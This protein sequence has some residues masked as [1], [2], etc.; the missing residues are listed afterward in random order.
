MVSLRLVARPM[1]EVRS[2][3]VII[4]DDAQSRAI[5][6]GAAGGRRQEQVEGLVTLEQR[7]L[8]R[9]DGDSLGC[10]A[11]GEVQRAVGRDKVQPPKQSRATC[12]S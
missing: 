6:H 11:S 12:H 3:T 8:C 9:L 10:L 4:E 5:G 7:I 2:I 1:I